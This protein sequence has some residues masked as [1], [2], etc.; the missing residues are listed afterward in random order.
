MECHPSGKWLATGGDDRKVLIF[1]VDCDSGTHCKKILVHGAIVSCVMFHP[2][3]DKLLV[4]LKL[5]PYSIFFHVSNYL[6]D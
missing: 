4:S 3:P 1:N 5:Y 2:D 6:T